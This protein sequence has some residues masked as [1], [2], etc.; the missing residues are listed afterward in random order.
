MRGKLII[1]VAP[2]GTGKSTLI[3]RLLGDF[4]ML[5]WSVSYTTRP[6]RVGEIHGKDYFFTDKESFEKEI[7]QDA[8]VEWANVH[9]N[10]YGTSR[11]FVSDGLE[12]GDFLLFDV[13]VQ[14]ADRLL[15]DFKNDATAIFITPPSIEDLS[16]RLKKRGTDSQE[17]IE[18]RLKNAREEL[19][20]KN[21]YDKLVVNE[22]VDQAYEELKIIFKDI[23]NP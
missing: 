11:R 9:G 7:A 19:K 23:I 22:K 12:R 3:K 1:I 21:D 10:Y 16:E 15:K 2:S 4:P 13:D 5:K 20:R 14:G 17:V 6:R 18:R 8:F